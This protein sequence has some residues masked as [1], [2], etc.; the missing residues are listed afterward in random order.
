MEPNYELIAAIERQLYK[1][2]GTEIAAIA[3]ISGFDFETIRELGG[4]PE[5]EL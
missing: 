3:L 5:G 2:D 1:L 4:L